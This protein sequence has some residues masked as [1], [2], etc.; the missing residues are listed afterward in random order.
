MSADLCR[1]ILDRITLG[2]TRGLPFESEKDDYLRSLTKGEQSFE[3]KHLYRELT[4]LDGKA[5]SSILFT[6]ILV[7]AYTPLRAHLGVSHLSE[8]H[9][10]WILDIGALCSL[11][12]V[13]LLM[14]VQKLYWPPLQAFTEGSL[15]EELLNIRN[16]RTIFYRVAWLLTMMSFATLASAFAGAF[17]GCVTLQYQL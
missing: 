3:L 15:S 7:L 16:R 1:A 2:V 17:V 6:S 13:L 5:Q 9:F 14:C 11:V 4:I 8:N 10:N 12:A